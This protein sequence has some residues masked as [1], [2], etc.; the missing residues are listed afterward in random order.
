MRRA[1]AV[2]TAFSVEASE[3]AQSKPRRRQYSGATCAAGG[4]K[5]SA[6][7]SAHSRRRRRVAAGSAYAG[8]AA[9]DGVRGGWGLLGA[10]PTKT[11]LAPVFFGLFSRRCSTRSRP[12][13]PAF[14]AAGFEGVRLARRDMPACCVDASLLCLGG[15]ARSPGPGRGRCN[16]PVPYTRTC[17]DLSPASSCCQAL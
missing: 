13:A 1:C 3:R 5:A 16:T 9:G 10:P 12:A 7:S 2:K 14:A 15:R 4:T 11:V 17:P 6:R 8:G